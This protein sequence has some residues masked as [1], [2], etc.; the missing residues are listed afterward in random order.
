MK[1]PPKVTL[2]DRS[3]LGFDWPGKEWQADYQ[4]V[5]V[6]EYRRNRSI[7]S[8][9]VALFSADESP[10]DAFARA[11]SRLGLGLYLYQ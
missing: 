5:D 1:T 2:P 11:G 8:H 10:S 4:S 3:K 6:G 7:M 9:T